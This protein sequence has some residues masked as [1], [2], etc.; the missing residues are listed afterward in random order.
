MKISFIIP[1]LNEEKI[2]ESSITSLRAF[3]ALPS[4]VIVSDGGSTDRTVEIARRLADTVVEWKEPRRQNIAMGRNAG[5]RVATGDLFVFVDADVFVPDMN[6]FFTKATARFEANSKLAGLIPR[7]EVL[8]SKRTYADAFWM[9]FF[10]IFN[11]FMNNVL[12]SP[13]APGE[14]QMIPVWAFKAVGGYNEKIVALEDMDMFMRL[15]RI[16]KTRLDPKLTV[17]HTGRRAH[18]VGW[19]HLWWQWTSNAFMV[20]FFSRSVS[21]EWIVVR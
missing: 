7:L 11:R 3:T 19:L 17:Y 13:T 5:A 12:R 15:R 2:L 16:G 4:E 10:N 21:K 6:A 8:E 14:F 20:K 18:K 1:V 9:G